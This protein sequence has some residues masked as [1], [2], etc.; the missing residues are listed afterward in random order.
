MRRLLALLLLTALA[1]LGSALGQTRPASP[2]PCA[3]QGALRDAICADPALRAADA[4]LRGLEDAL[5]RAT[6]RPAT[7]ALDLAAWRPRPET[8]A[9]DIADQ[10][11]EIEA[12]LR[13]DRAMRA[14]APGTA[15]IPR[16]ATLETRCL[17]AV[18]RDCRVTGA[19]VAIAEDGRTRV[20]W[21]TQTGFTER[22][23]IRA[24]IVLLGAVR[25]GWRPI[26]WSFEGHG[27]LPPRLS[28]HDGVTLLHAPGRGGGSG[29]RNTD[30]LYRRDGRGA[31][32]EVEMESWRAAA[33]P[34]L[35][36]GTA[37][38]QALDYDMT[39]LLAIGRLAKETDP[40]CCPSGGG[41]AFSLRLDGTRLALDEVLLDT[42]A[43]AQRTAP[44]SCPAER[45]TWRLQ[46]PEEWTVELS[47]EW[48]GT[49][50]ASDLA[51]R[52]RSGASGRETWF[53]FAA[54]Q[55]Y[56]GYSILPVETPGPATRE[57]G[58]LALDVEDDALPLLRFHAFDAGLD[59]IDLPARGRPAPR[60]LFMPG[61]G[62]ALHYGQ[63][64]GQPD[65]QSMSVGL[66][67]LDA[68]RPEAR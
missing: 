43:Q 46:A 50:A 21:Q 63:L 49:G 44:E 65:R 8:L 38:W 3:A 4:R 2:A 27:V 19:G 10:I 55:G 45:A 7:L 29:A 60:W 23:G 58:L 51:L 18:L 20:L 31:W 56:G 9:D 6:P 26:G 40:N 36:P 25:G 30:L 68:C 67:K 11:E 15:P 32:T 28:V 57:D 39:E 24:G 62:Q 1:P 54:A 48:P 33:A 41:V 14:I 35:P 53:V 42:V 17:G 16:P 12:R 34:R 13:V 37:I 59:A 47:G 61:L 52:L 5:R 66:W 22:D 64:P